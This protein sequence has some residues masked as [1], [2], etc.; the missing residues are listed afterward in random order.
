MCKSWQIGGED[1]AKREYNNPSAIA[2]SS[3][4]AINNIVYI[5]NNNR[6]RFRCP[7]RNIA[8]PKQK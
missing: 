2:M 6:P 5:A 8:Q 3:L 1:T 7:H 4:H